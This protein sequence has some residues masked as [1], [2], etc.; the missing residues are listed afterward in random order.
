[1]VNVIGLLLP[2]VLIGVVVWIVRSRG[3]AGP[4]GE[5]AAASL[6][7]GLRYAGLFAS[8][9]AAVVGLSRLLTYVLTPDLIGAD[10]AGT[11]ALGLALTLIATP[12]WVVLWRL[13]AHALRTD[14]VE[15]GS[16][17][18]GLYLVAASTGSLVTTVV[19]AI[20]LG[21][22][23]IG[24]ETYEPVSLALLV[25]AVPVWVGH[26]ALHRH[27]TYGPTSDVPRLG[28][29]A[30]ATVG[31]VALAV[32][33]GGIAR[34]GL[35]ELYWLAFGP[36]M[37]DVGTE[38]LL[39]GV[40]VSV[41]AA[42][43]WWWHWLH[44]GV[45]AERD[46]LWHAFVLLIAILGG[47][48]TAVAATGVAIA[49]TLEWLIGDPFAVRASAHFADLPAATAA[50]AVGAGTWWYHRRVL[51]SGDDGRTEPERVYEHLAAGVGLVAAAAGVTML[52]AAA[53]EAV[54]PPT[55][56][57]DD[58][59]GRGTLVAAITLLLVGTPVWWVAW[60]RIQRIA[61]RDPATELRAPSRRVHLVLLSGVGGLVAV[62]SL[63][64]VA[65]VGFRDLL[66]GVV[67]AATAVELR[68]AIGLV[69][70]AGA[71]ATYHLAV[72]RDDEA[73]AVP[74]PVELVRPHD[75]LLIGPDG[76]SLAA[77]VA[78]GTGARVR[79]LHR[80]D[81]PTVDVDADHVAEAIRAVHHRHVVVTVDH[82]GAV[83]V[84]P[85]ER[86]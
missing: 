60:R 77:A 26:L 53:I 54:A 16:V 50:L 74:E 64:V 5:A 76:R 22:A 49:T 73:R 36:P 40:V 58:L 63:V 18:W 75:V 70:T 41:V 8:L 17:G 6:R 86:T 19:T 69:V 66:D 85:Y 3:D 32:G 81:G 61:H 28:V 4:G 1:V 78:A 39:H 56:T 38:L 71:V 23:L 24:A 48:V 62:V 34:A 82:D 35:D 80:V 30:G 25:V 2:L 55:V 65:F 72:H 51:A 12:V 9:T 14:A 20:A 37:V 68:V 44:Q 15:R 11:L 84:I 43:V 29:L 52:I 10:R 13:S 7:R 67:G 83:E 59:G 47:L 46:G 21:D 79:S 27:P 33:V 57:V 45:D 31:L 42:P